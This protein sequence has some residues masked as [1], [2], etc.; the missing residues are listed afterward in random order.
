MHKIQIQYS[1]NTIYTYQVAELK[2]GRGEGSLAL[3]AFLPSAIFFTQN[4]GGGPPSLDPPLD[5][6]FIAT[7]YKGF[8]FTK[9]HNYPTKVV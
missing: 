4:K 1:T 9:L 6:Y 5:T 8:Q 7:P 3:P 2:K